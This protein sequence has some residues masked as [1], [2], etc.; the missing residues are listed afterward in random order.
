MID[1]MRFVVRP[2]PH[3]CHVEDEGMLL[4]EEDDDNLDELEKK[5]LEIRKKM[6]DH[7][8]PNELVLDNKL[9]VGESSIPNSGR[10]LF[11][12]YHPSSSLS[13]SPSAEKTEETEIE[14]KPIA[15]GTT[16]CYYTGH[17]HNF[18]SQK[19]ITDKSYLMSVGASDMMVDPGPLPSIKARYIN[20]PLNIKHINCTFVPDPD[21]TMFR[22]AVVATRDIRPGEEL[23]VSY[24]DMYWSQQKDCSGNVLK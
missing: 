17:R 16:I 23:F 22:C 2:L 20:D 21:P 9:V 7:L 18:L 11:Y 3:E 12:L 5:C 6:N 8:P 4:R 19:Y 24:G 1:R 15:S 13:S 10:G 14:M